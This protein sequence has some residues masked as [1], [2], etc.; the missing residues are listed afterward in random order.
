MLK[1]G[2]GR[3]REEKGGGKGV[4]VGGVEEGNEKV[5]EG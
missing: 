1:D 4:G 3:V 5:G 2:R